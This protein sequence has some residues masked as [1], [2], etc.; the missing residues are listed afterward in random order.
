MNAKVTKIDQAIQ[1]IENLRHIVTSLR[2][3]VA[4]LRDA[5][6]NT[7]SDVRFVFNWHEVFK[8]VTTSQVRENVTSNELARIIN[9]S[10]ADMPL[11]LPKAQTMRQFFLTNFEIDLWD[12]RKE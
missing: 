11:D 6:A 4:L 3:E 2:A 1:D 5:V 10:V 12:Y 7:C 8:K 9:S